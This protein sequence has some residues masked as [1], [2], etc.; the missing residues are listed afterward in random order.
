MYTARPSLCGLGP[1]PAESSTRPMMKQ[2]TNAASTGRRFGV[3]KVSNARPGKDSWQ[4][5]PKLVEGLDS[6][7]KQ[8][9]SSLSPKSSRKEKG[10]SDP[11]AIA[12]R[13]VDFVLLAEI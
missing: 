3:L 1:E 11:E 7:L 6:R 13:E 5:V 9:L 10:E 12:L 8:L 2:L 4:L